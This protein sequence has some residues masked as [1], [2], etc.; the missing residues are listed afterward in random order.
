MDVSRYAIIKTCMDGVASYGSVAEMDK[1]TSGLRCVSAVANGRLDLRLRGCG[2]FFLRT[3]TYPG[4]GGGFGLCALR[5]KIST[6]CC[7]FLLM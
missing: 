4:C 5:N 3:A 2:A 1:P 6:N 7:P